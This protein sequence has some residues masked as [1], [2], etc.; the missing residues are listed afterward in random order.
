M[1]IFRQICLRSENDRIRQRGDFNFFEISFERVGARKMWEIGKRGNIFSD[2]KKPK[3]LHSYLQTYDTVTVL[4]SNSLD[5]AVTLL[6]RPSSISVLNCMASSLR[7]CA[8]AMFPIQAS[9][10]LAL[11][12][13][14]TNSATMSFC[15]VAAKRLVSCV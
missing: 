5:T 1:D 6:A 8:A 15:A 7:S 2:K 3:G 13:P 10:T 9:S 4:P 14:V 12:L 11:W